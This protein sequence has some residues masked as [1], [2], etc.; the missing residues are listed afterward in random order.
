MKSLSL[1]TWMS[2]VGVVFGI[3][4]FSLIVFNIATYGIIDTASFEF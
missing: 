2:I 3:A 4:M 1:E